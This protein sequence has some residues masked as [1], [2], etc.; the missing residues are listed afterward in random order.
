VQNIAEKFKSLPWVI[1]PRPFFGL[2]WSGMY[3]CIV[4]NL[5]LFMTKRLHNALLS[6]CPSVGP[7]LHDTLQTKVYCIYT[8]CYLPV[9]S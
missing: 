5:G 8:C 2:D 4:K 1:K 3:N 7:V 9:K 6:V